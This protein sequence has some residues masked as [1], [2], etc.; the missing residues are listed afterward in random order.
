MTDYV[1]EQQVTERSAPEDAD[2]D[3]DGSVEARVVRKLDWNMMPL[4]FVLCKHE[5]PLPLIGHD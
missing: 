1:E 3:H 4:F 2:F 5:R